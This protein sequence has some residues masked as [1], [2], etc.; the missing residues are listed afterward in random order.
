MGATL[1][2]VSGATFSLVAAAILPLRA[3][4]ASTDAV[5][6]KVVMMVTVQVPSFYRVVIDPT[7]ADPGGAPIFRL[8]TNVPGHGGKSVIGPVVER[9]QVSE[10]GLYY[11]R[12]TRRSTGGEADLGGDA[13]AAITVMRYTVAPP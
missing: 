10:F 3:Q 9:F 4:G 7:T 11:F 5:G 8:I 13:V 6:G 12:P 1:W 2:R